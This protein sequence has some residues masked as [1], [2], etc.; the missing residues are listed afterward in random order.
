MS[1][2]PDRR[3]RSERLHVD[4][5]NFVA[6]PVLWAWWWSSVC[7]DSVAGAMKRDFWTCG[8]FSHVGGQGCRCLRLLVYMLLHL[9]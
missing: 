9:S 7:S 6:G 2:S 1:T 3:K 8:S 5:Q 4:V